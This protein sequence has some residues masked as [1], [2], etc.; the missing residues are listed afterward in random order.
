MSSDLS[1]NP[2]FKE[3]IE[4]G[5]PT[6]GSEAKEDMFSEAQDYLKGVH[7]E[8]EKEEESPLVPLERKF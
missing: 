5:F 4:Q 2:S 7:G 8:M 1:R 3:V 6:C